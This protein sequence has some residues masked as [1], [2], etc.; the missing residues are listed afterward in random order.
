MPPRTQEGCILFLCS[1]PWFTSFILKR[2]CVSTRLPYLKFT[3]LGSV[4]SSHLP[5]KMHLVSF[6]AFKSS[7]I[8]ACRVNSNTLLVI[9]PPDINLF[10]KI[11]CA[12]SH[13][14]FSCKSKIMIVVFIGV[15]SFEYPRDIVALPRFTLVVSRCESLPARG[16]IATKILKSFNSLAS[17]DV[18]KNRRAPFS[19]A[20]QP[21]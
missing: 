12:N 9:S 5:L 21:F 2:E 1:I 8:N 11:S 7:Y 3:R 13:H 20:K 15:E 14:K 4:R 10:Y 16:P 17:I 18:C 6:R 19:G